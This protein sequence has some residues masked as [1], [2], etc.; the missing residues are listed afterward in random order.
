[1]H[2]RLIASLFAALAGPAS[3]S[4]AGFCERM[5]AETG[6]K[7]VPDAP[8]QVWEVNKLGGLAPILFGGSVSFMM[9]IRAMD[10]AANGCRSEAKS[11]TCDLKAPSTLVLTIN[12]VAHEFKAEDNEAARVSILKSKIL[13]CETAGAPLN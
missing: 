13:R 5:A 2:L 6:M 12:G 4:A 3:A 10:T 8:G 7:P 9:Q 11:L 1:M